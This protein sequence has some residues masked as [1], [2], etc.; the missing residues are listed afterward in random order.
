ME[1]EAPLK[2]SDQSYTAKLT[3]EAPMEVSYISRESGIHTTPP[4]TCEPLLDIVRTLATL[5]ETYSKRWFYT[6]TLAVTFMKRVTHIWK[7]ESHMPYTGAVHESQGPAV[8]VSQVWCPEQLNILPRTFQIHWKLVSVSYEIERPPGPPTTAV[9]DGPI[10]PDQ[11]PFREGHERTNTLAI[12]GRRARALRKVREARLK[13]AVC[14][15]RATELLHRY[16]LR[17]GVA[18]LMDGDSVLS[19]EGEES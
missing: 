12:E 4:E 7:F 8:R 14:K 9:S 15:Q 18:E 2:L 5:Y 17:Y 10:D 13:A 6:Q 1:L 11:I 3:V 19:S 16:Y